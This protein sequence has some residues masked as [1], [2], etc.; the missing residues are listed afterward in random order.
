MERA[1]DIIIIIIIIIITIKRRESN[2]GQNHTIKLAGTFVE[3]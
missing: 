2:S 1:V 3:V